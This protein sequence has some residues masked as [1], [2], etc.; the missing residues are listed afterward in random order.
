MSGSIV[1]GS[2]PLTLATPLKGFPI[3]M[4]GLRLALTRGSGLPASGMI[5][6]G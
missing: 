1:G 2:P 6:R 5:G 4:L 3:N